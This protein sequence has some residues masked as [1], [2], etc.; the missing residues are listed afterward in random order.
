MKGFRKVLRSWLGV[1][2]PLDLDAVDREVERRRDLALKAKA[3]RRDRDP[4]YETPPSIILD[5]K[6]DDETRETMRRIAGGGR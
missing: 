6:A 4:T 3:C 2:L 5:A 1:P